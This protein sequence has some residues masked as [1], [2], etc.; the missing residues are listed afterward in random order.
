M[1]TSHVTH[2]DLPGAEEGLTVS[3]C[4]SHAGR[5]LLNRWVIAVCFLLRWS[6]RFLFSSV[7][8]VNSSTI[9]VVIYTIVIA[10][11]VAIGVGVS[12]L[13]AERKVDAQV[14]WSLHV[15]QSPMND[16]SKLYKSW[17]FR[18]YIKTVHCMTKTNV[19]RAYFDVVHHQLLLWI[20]H[21]AVGALEHGNLLTDNML[22]KVCVEQ[23]LQSEYGVTHGALV[24]KSGKKTTTKEITEGPCGS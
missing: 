12:G 4:V 17:R 15:L 3:T 6:W 8:T 19:L 21:G 23:R 2:V 9:I 11:A 16:L 10:K 13:C 1:F 18:I 22:V 5:L 14:S 7:V 20:V 24:Y